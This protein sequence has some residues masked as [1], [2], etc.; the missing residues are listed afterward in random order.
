MR[1]SVYGYPADSPGGGHGY[2]RFV[3]IR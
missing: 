2:F 1:L 3:C